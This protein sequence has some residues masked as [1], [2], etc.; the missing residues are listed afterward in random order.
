MS[1]LIEAK[2]EKLPP[3]LQD[4]VRDPH[5]QTCA[6]CGSQ[7]PEWVSTNLGILIC[8]QCSGIHRSLGTHI[9]KVRSLFLD[10][11][12]EEQIEAI[13]GNL[14]AK[15]IWEYAVPDGFEKP[16]ANDPL[17]VKEQW[18]RS[19]YEHKQYIET[20]DEDGETE[21]NYKPVRSGFLY[22]EGL[23]LKNW[24]KRWF[25]LTEKYLFYFQNEND[26]QPLGTILIRDCSIKLR[27]G[28]VRG[29][30]FCFELFTHDRNYFIQALD[31]KDLLGWVN[32]I[33][34]VKLKILQREADITRHASK[35]GWLTKQGGSVKTW[36]RRWCRIAGR[37]LY[38]YRTN[39]ESN[40]S[41]V[42]D[43]EGARVYTA[44]KAEKEFCFELWTPNRTYYF[45]ADEE[46]D[47]NA[48]VESLKNH[49]S[50]AIDTTKSLSS[51]GT[52]SLSSFV[53]SPSS[54]PGVVRASSPNISASGR[55]I[56][57]RE[58]FLTK[59]GQTIQSWKRRWFVL[60]ENKLSYYASQRDPS[61]LGVIMLDYCTVT[62][63]DEKELGK[64]FSF[65]LF[66]P[67]RTF[68]F[69]A[70]SEQDL[71]DWMSVLR[72]GDNKEVKKEGFLI[73]QGLGVKTMKRRWF[74]LKDNLYYYH[75]KKDPKPTGTIFIKDSVIRV[76]DKSVIPDPPTPYAFEVV[77]PMRNYFLFS[78]SDLERREW[79]EAIKKQ[80]NSLF[81]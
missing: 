39:E 28:K 36:H 58:G 78:E 46:G 32:D 75:E 63:G 47:R 16:T 77:T 56:L 50:T 18:I 30:S 59:R 70:D 13:K 52:Q 66:T 20:D 1:H 68:Y 7:Y 34:G 81:V 27:D 35:E 17:I 60:S 14:A 45:V 15:K 44:M 11:W 12:T 6:D 72:S 65:E 37:H 43:L 4:I 42:V 79:I 71:A 29:K 53:P 49:I 21:I 19:K 10:A 40:P 41:G 55:P 74:A 80:K 3:A 2:L 61:P 64:K 69:A 23:N 67:D 76:V 25:L 54:S 73:K 33:Q 24:K 48:W 5:N 62:D 57:Y 26:P 31:S 8:I 9:S 22:K 38:Y 51:M